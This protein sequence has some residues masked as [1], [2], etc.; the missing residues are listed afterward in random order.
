MADD[1]DVAN[2]VEMERINR[3]LANR[4]RE[5][6]C[7]IGMCHNCLELLTEA[8]FCDADCRDDYE[9]RLRFQR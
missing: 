5:T 8:H 4:T 1:A 2:E 7:Y 6:L 9:K 3:L